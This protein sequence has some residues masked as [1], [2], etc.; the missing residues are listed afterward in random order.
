MDFGRRNQSPFLE[1]ISFSLQEMTLLILCK[2]KRRYRAGRLTIIRFSAEPG[3]FFCAELSRLKAA[4][5][6]HGQV[7]QIHFSRD[8]LRQRGW[9]LYGEE[10]IMI[11]YE[12]KTVYWTHWHA[13]LWHKEKVGKVEISQSPTGFE[14][15]T[16]QIPGTL[17]LLNVNL[18]AKR[19]RGAILGDRL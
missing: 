11:V 7:T 8:I 9:L 4:M 12:F 16:S 5:T 17:T 13:K 10:V 19:M 1:I 15:M 2:W 14:P 18:R 6:C 3:A